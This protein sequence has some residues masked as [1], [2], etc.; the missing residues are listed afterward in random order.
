MPPAPTPSRAVLVVNTEAR[1]G[2]R[3][4]ATARRL[5]RD[6][7]VKL[8]SVRAEDNP[9]AFVEAVRV[10]VESGVSTVIVGGGDGSLRAC[11]DLFIG[12]SV[13]LGVLP[14]G[15][16]NSFARALKIPLELD[17]AVDV[18]AHGHTRR[19]D[20]GEIDGKTF[21]GCALMGLAPQIAQTVPHGLKAWAGRP[22]YLLWAA[23]QLARFRA[24]RLFVTIN[25]E[26]H[27]MDA[28]EVRIANG[29]FHGG[30]ELVEAARLDSGKLV[31]QAVVGEK[32]RHL[33]FNWAAQSLGSHLRWRKVRR[34]EAD[35]MVVETEPPLPISIDGEVLAKTPFTVRARPRALLVRA[36]GTSGER[37]PQPGHRPNRSK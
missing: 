23:A 4:L 19:I 33:L 10:A 17:G 9:G 8:A 37:T 36:P 35:M 25:G 5:L 1:R 31:I 7:G 27:E 15:T 2:R 29:P 6:R 21:A 16:A 13:V 32:R 26:R 24:F 14:L 20:L 34:F 18:I 11:V 30:V 28:V 12:S 22:G 3:A